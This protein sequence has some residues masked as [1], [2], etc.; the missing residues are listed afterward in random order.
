MQ[1]NRSVDKDRVWRLLVGI[2]VL[3]SLIVLGLFLSNLQNVLLTSP[4]VLSVSIRSPLEADYSADPSG[5]SVPVIATGII[6]EVLQD[7][8]NESQSTQVND[9]LLTPVPT[10][11]PNS[12]QQTTP[13]VPGLTATPSATLRFSL[14]PSRTMPPTLTPTGTL[15]TPTTTITPRIPTGVTPATL[16]PRV[17]TAITPHPWTDTPQPPTITPRPSTDTLV[18]PTNTPHPSTD[19]LVPPTI[20]PRPFTNTPHPPTDTVEP[21]THTPIPPTDDPYPYPTD[22]PYP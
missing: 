5:F 3:L 1:V 12:P 21:P 14:T 13:T 22:P 9:Q 16:T 2:V 8:Q 17:P 4:S 18:P 6:G 19:T 11:T 20:T 7:Q 15:F 10:I